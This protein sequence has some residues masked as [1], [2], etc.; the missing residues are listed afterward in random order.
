MSYCNLP[1]MSSA[2]IVLVLLT[3]MPI[4]ETNALEASHHN[5]FQ[6]VDSSKNTKALPSSMHLFDQSMP[7][8]R[9]VKR[10]TKHET[11][12][13]MLG[14]L[15]YLIINI[16]ST[17][18]QVQQ[19]PQTH[20][21][22]K[23][24]QLYQRTA[25][26]LY[27][28][29]TELTSLKHNVFEELAKSGSHQLTGKAIKLTSE[30]LKVYHR[31]LEEI[32]NELSSLENDKDG[33]KQLVTLIGGAIKCTQNVQALVKEYENIF[34]DYYS[35]HYLVTVELICEDFLEFNGFFHTGIS[36]S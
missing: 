12:D 4:A 5:S 8:L 26:R 18:N 11:V 29:L 1:N 36:I 15:E 7:R 17:R 27:A 32:K 6:L 25:D 28:M 33:E 2:W 9:R 3:A 22:R 19:I 16:T 30:A 23:M 35:K 20:F 21:S 34:N 13:E 24:E 10:K 31:D 14:K